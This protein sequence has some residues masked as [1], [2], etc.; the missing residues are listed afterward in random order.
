MKGLSG[1]TRA[2][3]RRE[4]APREAPLRGQPPSIPLTLRGMRR[5]PSRHRSSA[6]LFFSLLSVLALAFAG[7]PALAQA[8]CPAGDSSCLEY[9]TTIPESG[10]GGKKPH[11]QEASEPG[12][13]ASKRKSEPNGNQSGESEP[14]EE[15][16]QQSTG[17]GGGDHKGS[18]GGDKG[19]HQPIAK[20]STGV[21]EAEAV[22]TA[23]G[24]N[25]SSTDGGGGSSPLLPIIIAVLVLGAISIGAVIYRQRRQDGGGS[26]ANAG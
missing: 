21:Q 4:L 14:S 6:T 11:V 20:A 19:S 16:Q 18:G 23:T 15:A 7:L 8:E 5:P 22:P 25:A 9:E 3:D 17:G 13:E 12:A 24:H 26:P 2:P 10:A 1:R